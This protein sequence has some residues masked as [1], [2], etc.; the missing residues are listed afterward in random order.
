VLFRSQTH[1]IAEFVEA[2][3]ELARPLQTPLAASLRALKDQ[4]KQYAAQLR[5]TGVFNV[6]YQRALVLCL[7]GMLLST[8]DSHTTIEPK[9]RGSLATPIEIG[10]IHP[11]MHGYQRLLRIGAE[12]IITRKWA[13]GV[14]EIAGL[15]HSLDLRQAAALLRLFDLTCKCML[16]VLPA[17]QD[18]QPLVATIAG[19]SLTIAY[20]DRV[21]SFSVDLSLF[22]QW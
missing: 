2:L 7:W 17:P 21:R 1:I 19:G 13:E 16:G 10:L 6:T 14:T 5:L 15:F 9:M 11:R 3:V 8:I 4:A 18:P 12:S 22:S 20:A